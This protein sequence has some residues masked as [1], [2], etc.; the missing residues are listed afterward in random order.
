MSVT[1]TIHGGEIKEQFDSAMK[2]ALTECGLE[3]QKYAKYAC[4]VD[5]GLLRNSIAY[6]RGG[7]GANLAI[8]KSDR[9]N[10]VGEYTPMAS[11]NLGG[12]SAYLGTRVDYSEV[13]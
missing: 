10:G 8:Y 5:T 13:I 3:A 2:K 12:E 11:R 6:A 4:P 7:E 9:D 1:F